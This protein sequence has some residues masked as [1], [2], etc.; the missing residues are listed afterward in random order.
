MNKVLTIIV[1]MCFLASVTLASELKVDTFSTNPVTLEMCE[2]PNNSGT[3][4]FDLTAAEAMV[5]APQPNIAFTWAEDMAISMIIDDPSAYTST[6]GNVYVRVVS[7]VDMNI[8]SVQEVTLTVLEASLDITFNGQALDTLERCK[9]DGIVNLGITSDDPTTVNNIVW[10]AS[11]D[12]LSSLTGAST[13]ID[14]EYSTFIYASQTFEN[15]CMTTDT[16]FIRV[17]SLLDLVLE[18]PKPDPCEMFG[19]YCPGTLIRIQSNSLDPECYPDATY[20]WTPSS[21]IVT[22]REGGGDPMH[23]PGADTTLNVFIGPRDGTRPQGPERRQMVRTT[24]NHACIE[25]D[26]LIYFVTDTTPDLIGPEVVCPGASFTISIDT[27]YLP[28]FTDYNW[29]LMSG[30]GIEFDCGNCDNM[31]VVTGTIPEDAYGAQVL[32]TVRGTKDDCCEATGS[33]SFTVPEQPQIM[34]TP[35]CP[36]DNSTLSTNETYNEYS[37]MAS[38]TTL[39]DAS[40]AS[41]TAINVPDSSAS[42]AVTV[43]D[44]NG[45]TLTSEPRA[46]QSRIPSITITSEAVCPGENSQITY[47]GLDQ[48]S[49]MWSTTN[50]DVTF[51]DPAIRAPIVQNV[52]RGGVDVTLTVTTALGCEFTFVHNVMNTDM[53]AEIIIPNAFT[54]R[55]TE[56]QANRTFQPLNADREPISADLIEDFTVWNRWGQKVYDNESNATGWNGQQG[57]ELAPSDV[58]LYIIKLASSSCTSEETFKGDVTLIR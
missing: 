6:G 41:P 56:N 12:T 28:N 19:N 11:R 48:Q 9:E 31:P 46:L 51:S 21:D 39:D 3:A 53:Q 4:T 34:Y 30:E 37:W 38:G 14:P 33:T 16:F 22:R 17:D 47:S 18:A 15:G 36:G 8:M 24:T 27:N 26:T 49:Y 55:S 43:V 23:S 42:V 52:P 50:S 54:P 25:R 35:Y 7:T 20:K 29:N 40:S 2:S 5:V 13:S 45:C 57:G 44:E 10:S 32:I 1:G 58:Y